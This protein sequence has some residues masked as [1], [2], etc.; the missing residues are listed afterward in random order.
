MTDSEREALNLFKKLS[1]ENQN[2]L[3]AFARLA[4]IAENAVKKSLKDESGMEDLS[5]NQL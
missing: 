5:G 3:L 1:Q 2:N 4:Y